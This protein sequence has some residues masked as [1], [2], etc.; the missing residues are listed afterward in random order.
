M[1][2]AEA[3]MMTAVTQN[4]PMLVHQLESMEEELIRISSA[5][6]RIADE[7]SNLSAAGTRPADTTR[8]RSV[9]PPTSQ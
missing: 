5:L 4:L 3:N 6:E 2:I 7:I 9:E 1:T 8:Q